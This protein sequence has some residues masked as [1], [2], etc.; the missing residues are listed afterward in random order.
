MTADNV[1]P[2]SDEELAEWVGDFE[3]LWKPV[4]SDSYPSAETLIPY[5]MALRI[6]ESERL[7][8][9][10]L[11][12]I[13]RD[14]GHYTGEHGLER[15]TETADS[16]VVDWL[17]ME[18]GRQPREGSIIAALREWLTVSEWS[19]RLDDAPKRQTW[20]RGF[21]DGGAA[22]YGVALKF[23]DQLVVEHAEE[24]HAERMAERRRVLE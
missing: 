20:A 23:L 9:N 10:L 11:A 18:D 2:I 6:W 15:S 21:I 3:Q 17:T 7:L 13:H 12:R 5:R 19:I 8:G 16:K 22:A 24:A 1:E 4:W 14:G